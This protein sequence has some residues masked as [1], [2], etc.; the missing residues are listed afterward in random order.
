MITND[1]HVGLKN[2]T[3]YW[4]SEMWP[5]KRGLPFSS[6]IAI[7]KGWSSINWIGFWI[8]KCPRWKWSPHPVAALKQKMSKGLFCLNS[9]W[10]FVWSDCISFDD[11]SLL[12]LMF[13]HIHV[14]KSSHGLIW[15]LKSNS[16]SDFR[17]F[18]NSLTGD[19]K[20]GVQH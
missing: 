17:L 15:N 11:C 7:K 3:G 13:F 9:K 6:P 4:G 1:K 14:N 10:L 16:I 2:I 5:R 19:C 20:K 8:S 12:E 18:V